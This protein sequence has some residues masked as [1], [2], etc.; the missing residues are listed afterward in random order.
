MSVEGELEKEEKNK[1]SIQKRLPAQKHNPF[2][3]FFNTNDEQPSEDRKNLFDNY[4]K[5]YH[6]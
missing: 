6:Q 4:D 3:D 5:L 1:E 2:D